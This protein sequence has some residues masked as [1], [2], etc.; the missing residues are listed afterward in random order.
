MGPFD[1]G[2]EGDQG[3]VDGAGLL[4]SAHALSELADRTRVQEGD[5][6]AMAGQQR[7]GRAFVA[8]SG[9]HRHEVDLVKLTEG[10]Q[11]S[12][13]FGVVGEARGRAVRPW[14]AGRQVPPT[15]SLKTT[16]DEIEIQ[17]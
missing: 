8:A 16:A 7:K 1:L 3:R 17:G 15:N 12:D 10:D 14:G 9:F 2:E 5:G 6:E 11:K 13:A 4:E